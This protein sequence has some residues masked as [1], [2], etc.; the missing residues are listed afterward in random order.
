MEAREIEGKTIDEAIERACREFGVTRD[1]LHID[2]L[3]EGTPGFLGL[4][5]GFFLGLGQRP[6]A[7]GL[8]GIAG[9]RRLP[10]QVQSAA[11]AQAIHGF[12]GARRRHRAHGHGAAGAGGIKIRRRDGTP[13]RGRAV[14]R[15]QMHDEGPPM[16]TEALA[17]ARTSSYPDFGKKQGKL[18]LV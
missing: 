5:G 17:A 1:K 12:D 13:Q 2:I 10:A 8:V 4:L 3:S 6:V 7:V 11:F 16:D 15:W 9:A 14:N 18:R